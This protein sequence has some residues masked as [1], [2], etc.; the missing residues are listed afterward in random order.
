MSSRRSDRW[1]EVSVQP[2]S[3][4]SQW[5]DF[6][7][8]QHISPSI[9]SSFVFISFRMLFGMNEMISILNK[10]FH[11]RLICLLTRSMSVR[12]DISL[13]Q[14]MKILNGNRQCEEVLDLFEQ[15][16]Q[17]NTTH[18]SSYIIVQALK[19][20]TQMADLQRG[21]EIHRLVSSRVTKDSYLLSS[22]IHLYS[23]LFFS[24]LEERCLTS[25]LFE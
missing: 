8:L 13:S 22:L 19:A 6:I 9:I 15:Y 18:L 14:R 24:A 17:A 12:S 4:E 23:E 2:I 3:D 10:S 5:K 11:H 21:E 7:H 16:K 1:L 25:L 20:C